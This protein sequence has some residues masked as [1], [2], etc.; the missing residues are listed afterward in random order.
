MTIEME[1]PT[2]PI[3]LSAILPVTFTSGMSVIGG[4]CDTPEIVTALY[5]PGRV[6][7]VRCTVNGAKMITFSNMVRY[8]KD[9]DKS[10]RRG[11]NHYK[12]DHILACTFSQGQL[13]GVVRA[14]MKD[15]SYKVLVSLVNYLCLYINQSE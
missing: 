5:L 10:V 14:S 8:F 15:K 3:R 4:G 6:M 1:C 9:E 11:E 13:M 2:L 12:S 7:H